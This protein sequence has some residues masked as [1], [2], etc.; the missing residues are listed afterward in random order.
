MSTP[1]TIGVEYRVVGIEPVRGCG[2]LLAFV[3][4][5]VTIGGVTIRLQ[6]LQVRRTDRGLVEVAAPDGATRPADGCRP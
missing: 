5:S 4:A 1:E 6:G 3:N 2:R